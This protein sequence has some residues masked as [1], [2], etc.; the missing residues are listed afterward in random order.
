MIQI[1][2]KDWMIHLKREIVKVDSVHFISPFIGRGMVKHLIDCEKLVDVKVITRFNLNDF[3]AG[4]SSIDALKELLLSG[5]EVRGLKGLHSKLYVFGKNSGIVGSANFTI[6]G[7]NNNYELGVF[8]SLPPEVKKIHDYFYSLWNI[9]SSPL[10]LSQLEE[11]E[12]LILNSPSVNVSEELPDYGKHLISPKIDGRKVFLKIFGKADNRVSA[13]SHTRDEIVSS[14]CHFALTFSG[15]K[16]RP[17][18]YRDG[19]IVYMARM[20]E[21]GEYGIFG[22]GSALSHNDTRDYACIQDIVNIPWKAEWPVYI[23]VYNTQFID[24]LMSDC[25]QLSELIENLDFESFTGTS[26]RNRIGE[27]DINPWHSLRQQAD[28]EL[29][30]LAGEWLENKFEEAVGSVGRVPENFI[31]SL[32]QGSWKYELA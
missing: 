9:S 7:F 2:D 11:W 25:P 15:K 18:K 28:V 31:N 29:T 21:G 13:D 14:H 17:R 6:G 26:F 22:R 19:D 5:A 16:G 12:E 10:T 24:G 27:I 1:I 20:L 23:R 32:Y 4:V 30:N 3:R 8:L